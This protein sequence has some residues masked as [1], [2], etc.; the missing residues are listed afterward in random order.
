MDIDNLDKNQKFDELPETYTIFITENDKYGKGLPFYRIERVNLETG[1]L[2]HDGEHIL[3]VNG[4]YRGEDEIGHLMHDF[5]CSDPNDMFNKDLADRTRY[6][7]ETKEG[8]SIMCK[9][10]E[11]MRNKAREEGRAEER[12]ESTIRTALK[13]N[14]SAEQIVQDLVE[15]CGLTPDAAK[16][17]I[18]EYRKQNNG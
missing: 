13:Y 16:K 4:A 11:D 12:I 17:C 5:C 7:K 1:E 9:E 18:E 15:D 2:F 14:A 6:F 8:Q 10:M 3:Y